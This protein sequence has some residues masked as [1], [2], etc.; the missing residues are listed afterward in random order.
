MGYVVQMNQQ[1]KT[2]TFGAGCFWH[3][4]EMFDQVDGVL[5]TTVG[6]M[7]GDVKDPTYAQV[8]SDDT[9]HAEVT[10]IMFDSHKISYEQLLKLFWQMH[11]PTQID[12]QGPDIGKQYRSV[13]FT[14]SEVQKET[15][16]RLKDELQEE[17]N[18]EIVTS[19]E[20]ATDF[21]PAEDYHQKYYQKK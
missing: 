21:Y 20:P 18:N 17:F 10:Q 19:I 8:C 2:A 16:E 3:P 4:Q 14:H 12:R 15:A 13:V 5:E 9:G 11:D 1:P 7:G 6:Y